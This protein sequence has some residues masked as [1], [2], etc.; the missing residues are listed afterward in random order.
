MVEMLRLAWYCQTR[1]GAEQRVCF[2]LLLETMSAHRL[3]TA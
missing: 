2:A 3:M 1:H